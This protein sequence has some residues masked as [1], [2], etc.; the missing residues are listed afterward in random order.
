[1]PAGKARLAPVSRQG[2]A[3]QILAEQF[4]HFIR[5]LLYNAAGVIPH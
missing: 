5:K 3:S 1:L 2:F 4:T